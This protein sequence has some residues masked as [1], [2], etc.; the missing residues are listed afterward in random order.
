MLMSNVSGGRRP[1]N[2]HA[3]IQNTYIT[4]QKSHQPAWQGPEGP[5]MLD[6]VFAMV[7]NETGTAWGT[8]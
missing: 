4:C 3:S 6:D 8:W 5:D 1:P 2:G 7:G